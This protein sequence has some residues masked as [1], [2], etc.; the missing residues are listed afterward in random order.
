MTFTGLIKILP[1]YWMCRSGPFFFMKFAWGVR[2]LEKREKNITETHMHPLA[3][4]QRKRKKKK[5]K[6]GE[7]EGKI[8]QSNELKIQAGKEWEAK[9]F[10]QLYTS[11]GRS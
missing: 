4:K 3:N 10:R 1:L 5:R 7:R 8:F 9:G 11:S 2:C 6:W